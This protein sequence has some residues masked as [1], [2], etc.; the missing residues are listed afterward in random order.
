MLPAATTT[1]GRMAAAVQMLAQATAK[2]GSLDATKIAAVLHEG[3]FD[4]VIGP[5]AFDP[6]GDIKDLNYEFYRWQ[7]GTAVQLNDR[8]PPPPPP[9]PTR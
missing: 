7:Q 4:T 3:Q 6:K 9:P 2:A 1:I 5:V 8:P